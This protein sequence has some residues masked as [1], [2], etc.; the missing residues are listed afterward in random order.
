MKIVYLDA[1]TCR[2]E[3]LDLTALQNLGELTLYDRSS[4][5]ESLIRAGNAEVILTNKTPIDAEMMDKLPKL[6]YIGVTAT[7]YNIVDVDAAKKRGIVVTNAKNYS[8]MSVAQHV[9]ALLLT[10]TNRIAEHNSLKRWGSQPDFCFYDHSL[11]EL[12][13]KTMGLVGIGDIGEKTAQLAKAFE[14]NVLVHRKSSTAHPD[15]RTVS[16]EELIEKSDVVSLHCPL[17]TENQGFMD[18]NM[19]L[20]MKKSAILINTGRGPL[21]N[22][23]HLAEALRNGD[24]AGAGL[25][26]LSQEPPS[27]PHVLENVP[28]LVLSPHVA[29]ASYEARVRLMEIVTDNLAAWANGNPKNVLS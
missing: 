20:K 27:T 9:F 4:K 11:T 13:G 29:W 25:D 2:T 17:T 28:N 10:F 1:F 6:K 22:E 12:A 5:E 14:M 3:E 26:V 16:L 8:S 19:F 21:I 7:G 23:T 24:I 15:Y 18:K